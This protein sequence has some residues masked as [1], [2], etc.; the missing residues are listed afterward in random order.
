MTNQKNDSKENRKKFWKERPHLAWGLTVFILAVLTISVFFAFYRYQGLATVWSKILMAFQP[1]LIGFV[2]AYLMNPIER[3]IEKKML[4]NRLKKAK[5]EKKAR[6]RA[7]N[8][9]TGISILIFCGIVVALIL[10]IVPQTIMSIQQLMVSL[11]DDIRSFQSWVNEMAEQNERVKAVINQLNS[12]AGQEENGQFSMQAIIDWVTNEFLPKSQ[13]LLESITSGVFMVAKTIVNFVIGIIIAI[14]VLAT[15]DKLKAQA[16]KLIYSIFQPIRAN[17]LV[18]TIRESDRIFGGFIIG[19]IIDSFIIGVICYVAMLIIDLPYPA[20]VSVIIGV[21]NVVPF[22][23]PFIGAIPCVLLIFLINPLQA[24]FFL[25][26]VLCLQTFDGYILS[27][28]ILGDTTGL[29]TFWVL[30]AILTFGGVFGVPGMVLGV[31]VFGVIYY[32][33]KDFMRMSLTKKK[34][35]V[36]EEAYQDLQEINP[37]TK[38][39]FYHSPENDQGR[40]RKRNN[41]ISKMKKN[42]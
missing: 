35:P 16:K 20:L 42:N 10:L 5:D 31:P 24:L 30:F 14:Y 33:V 36:E 11:P 32:I 18:N 40:H 41:Y 27:P 8:S 9:A 29:N 2:V 4:K 15:K 1:I 19:K 34:L 38:E 26:L 3:R 22:F 25:I 39:T 12:M 28:K 6:R 23:G 13:S 17:W 37:Q 21:T 7:R